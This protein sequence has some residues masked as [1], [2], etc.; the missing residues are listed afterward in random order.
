MARNAKK[1]SDAVS[2]IRRLLGDWLR[3]SEQSREPVAA[4]LGLLEDID[5]YLKA[6]GAAVAEASP[7]LSAGRSSA[8]TY[9]IEKQ[10]NDQ[11]VLVEH[12]ANGSSQP[13]RVS[14]ELYMAV[15]AV[16]AGADEP[17][18]FEAVTLAVSKAYSEPAE[19]QL[20]ATLRFMMSV[21]PPLVSRERSRYRPV[22]KGK[23][24]TEAKNAWAALA[25][26]K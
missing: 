18:D 16:L 17:M 21:S 22:R 5:D 8:A 4:I 26:S 19:F 24:E 7:K 12:R 15:A 9:T 20:R 23:F 6:G 13:F 2:H 3:T 14:K 25:K 11:E 10:R 1:A